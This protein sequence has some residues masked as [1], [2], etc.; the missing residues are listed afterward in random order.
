MGD[1]AL[2]SGTAGSKTREIAEKEYYFLEGEIGRFDQIGIG[3]KNWSITVSGAV[4]TAAFYKSAP[5]LLLI[6]SISSL[7]FWIT[8]ARWKQ[9]QHLHM[10][11]LRDVEAYL[12]N[13]Y[14][15]P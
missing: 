14:L 10:E 1:G 13:A 3:V 12:L 9:Y 2:V 6:S 5:V 11:R 4:M 8:E 15:C 7:L